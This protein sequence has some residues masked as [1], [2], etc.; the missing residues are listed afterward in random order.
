MTRWRIEF[1][2]GPLDGE[3]REFEWAPDRLSVTYWTRTLTDPSVVVKY[4]N[5]VYELRG[6][7]YVWPGL[8]KFLTS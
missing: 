8:V 1:V 6:S 5:V 7:Q 4:H 3:C 2:G